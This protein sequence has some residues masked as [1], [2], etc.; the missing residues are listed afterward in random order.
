MFRLCLTVFLCSLDSYTRTLTP[1]CFNHVTWMSYLLLVYSSSFGRCC[2][3]PG[4][5]LTS[6]WASW[7]SSYI[8]EMLFHS[9]RAVSGHQLL[10]MPGTGSTMLQQQVVECSAEATP[11]QVSKHS[12]S[13]CYSLRNK[14]GSREATLHQSAIELR[15]STVVS[16]IRGRPVVMCSTPMHKKGFSSLLFSSVRLSSRLICLSFSCTACFR[17]VSTQVL[18]HLYG[19]FFRLMRWF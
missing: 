13:P 16:A 12:Q 9:F 1:F 3:S 10:P 5:H 19:S 11:T 15:G 7:W 6:N 2:R 18:S 8:S 14:S 17:V 4:V